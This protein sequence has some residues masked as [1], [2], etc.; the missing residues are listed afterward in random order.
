MQI[1]YADIHKLN[2]KKVKH[3]KEFKELKLVIEE[4]KIKKNT[5]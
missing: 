2:R 3:L 1:R 4:Y 5:N